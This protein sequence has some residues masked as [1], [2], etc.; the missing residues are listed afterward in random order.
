ME[1]AALL[2][3]MLA[4]LVLH[5]GYRKQVVWWEVLIPMLPVLII[6]PLVKLVA[7]VNQTRD[8]ERHGGWCR[9][10]IYEED[11]DEWIT[12]LC[13][14]TVD[15]GGGKS[16]TETY[17]CSY[18]LYHPP[19]WYLIDSN[20]Y[21]VELTSQQFEWLAAKFGNR[22]F[23][24][25]HRHYY[26][27][28][29][30]EYHTVWSGSLPTLQPVTTEHTY[31]NRVQATHGVV[32]FPEITKAKAKELGLFEY[33]SVTDNL[34][35]RAILGTLPKVDEAN[36]ILQVYNALKGRQKQIRVWV[37]IFHNKPLSIAFDQE[38]YWK[39]GNKNEFVVCIGATDKNE[40]PW[41]HPFCWSPDGN[42]SNDQLKINVRDLVQSRSGLGESLPHIVDDITKR[43]D[44]LFQRKQFCE[45]SYLT[46]DTPAWATWLVY[47][48]V[49]LST[50]A[51][52][53][54]IMGNE[55]TEDNPTGSIDK[56]VEWLS[57]R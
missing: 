56:A 39:G 26:T 3:P 21:R 46:V 28:D 1:W 14:R 4:G 25:M 5:Y 43:C 33:P 37:L 44:E 2:I 31:E 52:C 36:T 32:D 41:C 9:K 10:A 17:D 11:W 19:E 49:I 8:Y 42:T 40:G 45:F 12:Q 20:D 24:D 16:H 23:V 53:L 55:T 54:W 57:R 29:G 30:D 35:D 51:L 15:D 22:H 34:N 6:V 48:L 27:D 13:T 18:R 50:G 7:E 47:I 38:S